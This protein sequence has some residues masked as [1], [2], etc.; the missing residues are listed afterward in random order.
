MLERG[1]RLPGITVDLENKVVG[2]DGGGDASLG[3]EAVE[4]EEI[5]V[6]I[7]AE[8]GVEDSVA[9]EDSGATVGVDGV[10]DEKRGLVEIVLTDEG[11]D[12]VME[13]QA[14]GGKGR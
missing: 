1:V 11:E 14:L 2:N 13:V 9:G 8:K 6:A 7:L 10:A 3:D 5:S 12:A 4:R